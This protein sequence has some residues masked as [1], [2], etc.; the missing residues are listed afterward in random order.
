M[1]FLEHTTLI[2]SELEWKLLYLHHS[3]GLPLT[4]PQNLSIIVT[5]F[6]TPPSPVHGA[7]FLNRLVNQETSAIGYTLNSPAESGTPTKGKVGELQCATAA[8]AEQFNCIFS[9]DLC[10]CTSQGTSINCD[11][12]FID[13]EALLM[14]NQITENEGSEGNIKLRFNNGKI[15]SKVSTSGLLSIQLQLKNHI[16]RRINREDNCYV[17]TTTINGCHSC[18]QGGN[19]SIQCKSEVFADLESTIECPSITGFVKCSVTGHTSFLQIFTNKKHLLE[20]CTVSC[21]STKNNFLLN[22][23]LIT[24]STFQNT[25]DKKFVRTQVLIGSGTILDSIYDLLGSIWNTIVDIV[26][27]IVNPFISIFLLIVVLILC[28]H[29]VQGGECRRTRKYKRKRHLV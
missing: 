26:M 27:G 11:C 16:V 10:S 21:G 1:S 4:L 18:G 25:G 5:G 7:T 2:T 19:I 12:D 3:F 17:T 13:I 6:S 20:N 14:K 24:E 22:G 8:D 15:I 9:E 23:T 28:C 29:F